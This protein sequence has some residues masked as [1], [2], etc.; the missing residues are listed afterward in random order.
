M[1]LTKL[2]GQGVL[3]PGGFVLTATHCIEWDGD[4]GMALGEHYLEPVLTS[5]GSRFNLEPAAADPIADIAVLVAPDN[6]QFGD[7]CEAFEAWIDSVDPVP[8]SR[9]FERWCS[10]VPVVGAEQS[11]IVHCLTHAGGW[12]HGKAT[13]RYIKP[14]GP[15]AWVTFEEPIRSGTSGGPIVDDAGLLVGI[16]SFSNEVSTGSCD[17][18]QPVAAYALPAWVLAASGGAER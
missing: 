7:D 15:R 3:I 10:P 6:Q 11:F 17:G 5:V 4:A 2:G 12:V 8:L 13:R 1:K 14:H 9:A 18:A 16:V